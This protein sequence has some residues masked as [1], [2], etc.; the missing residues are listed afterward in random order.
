MTKST[1]L[2]EGL[3]GES[4]IR[5]LAEAWHAR[6]LADP[7]V[8][9]AF[10]HGFH[11][12]HTARLAAYWT[13]ALGGPARYSGVLG[14]E[15]EVVR[16]HSGNGDAAEMY[17]A[18]AACFAAALAD[19]GVTDGPLRDRTLAWWADAT[20][21]MDGYPENRDDVPP[22]LTIPRWNG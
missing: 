1:T 7:I 16:M 4:G 20:E 11:P 18:G 15:T 19:V 14:T 5:R 2:F 21:R 6:C 10:S 3:G 17:A 9:H 13:E 12:E 8:A 22:G